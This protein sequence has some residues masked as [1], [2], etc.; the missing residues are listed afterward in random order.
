[1]SC[2]VTRNENNQIVR[3]ETPNGERSELFIKIAKGLFNGDLETSLN[4]FGT[5]YNRDVE[6]VFKGVT[7]NRFVYPTGEPKLFY[8]IEGD[9]VNESLEQLSLNFDGGVI[10]MGFMNPVDSSFMSVGSVNTNAS[11]T[12]QEIF[13]LLKDGIILPDRVH[14]NNELRYKGRGYRDASLMSAREAKDSIQDNTDNLVTLHLDGTFTFENPSQFNTIETVKGNQVSGTPE[15][16]REKIMSGEIKP[17]DE[18]LAILQTS[19]D[20]FS[21][22]L[23]TSPTKIASA[24]ITQIENFIKNMGFSVTT[25]QEYKKAYKNRHGNDPDV[26]ALVDLAEKL[27][28]IS[29]NSTLEEAEALFSEEVTHLAIEGYKDQGTLDS[30]LLEV[31][32][33]PEYAQYAEIY[34]KKYTEQYSDPIGLETAVRKEVLGKIIAN[35]LKTRVY[36]TETAPTILQS[37]FNRLRNFFKPSQKRAIEVIKRDVTEAISQSNVEK[38]S[39]PT[40]SN[41]VFYNL[42]PETRG[43]TEIIQKAYASADVL[44][45]L[46]NTEGKTLSGIANTKAI[47]NTTKSL[48]EVKVITAIQQSTEFAK[49]LSERVRSKLGSEDFSIS[50]IREFNFLKDKMVDILSEYQ[51]Y[52][53]NDDNFSNPSQLKRAR[54][55]KDIVDKVKSNVTTDTKRLQK[56]ADDVVNKIIEREAEERGFTEEKTQELRDRIFGI[57]KDINW[58]T[59]VAGLASEANEFTGMIV[60]EISTMLTKAQSE[61]AR[62]INPVV[63]KLMDGSAQKYQKDTAQKDS[64]GKRTGY[65]RNFL[66]QGEYDKAERDFIVNT[67]TSLKPELKREDV[68]KKLSEK[69]TVYDILDDL[70]LAQEFDRKKLMDFDVDNSTMMFKQEYYIKREESYDKANVSTASR[71]AIE[72]S[73]RQT[74]QVYN[75]KH[76]LD[77]NGNVDRSK[78]TEEDENLERY[79]LEQRSRI[80]S[81]ISESGEYYFGLNRAKWSEMTQAQKDSIPE[82]M[83]STSGFMGFLETYKG[84]VLFLDGVTVDSLPDDARLAFDNANMN[85]LRAF[86]ASQNVP[87]TFTAFRDKLV[88]LEN[89]GKYAEA[90]QWAMANGALRYTEEYYETNGNGF[91]EQVEQ[92]LT[93]I[94]DGIIRNAKQA[95]FDLLKEASKLRGEIL[96]NRRDPHN[97]SEI[98]ASDMSNSMK[99]KVLELDAQIKKLRGEL[100]SELKK[101]LPQEFSAEN[102]LTLMST[103]T[104]FQRDF[105]ASGLSLIE[106]ATKNMT[107]SDVDRLGDFRTYLRQI[108]RS[109]VA[110]TYNKRFDETIER[111]AEMGLVNLE[112]EISDPTMLD[113]FN[114]RAIKVLSEQFAKERVASY[115]KKYELNSKQSLM[116]GMRRGDIKISDMLDPL[117][118][119]N[120]E[121]VNPDLRYLDFTPDY[122]WADAVDTSMM[123]DEYNPERGKTP[124]F[125]KYKDS[126]FIAEVGVTEEQART[127]RNFDEIEATNTEMWDYFKSLYKMSEFTKQK[128]NDNTNVFQLPQITSSVFEKAF[129]SAG[130]KGRLKASV[131]DLFS[132]IIQDRVDEKEYGEY[133]DGRD[134]RSMGIRTPPRYF[135][136]KVDDN[137]SLTENYVS[138]YALM[139]ME[140]SKYNQKVKGVYRVEQILNKI[141]NKKFSIGTPVKG[142]NGRIREGVDSNTLKMAN[143]IV[144]HLLY[145]VKQTGKYEITFGGKVVDITKV[146]RTF[147]KV[148]SFKNLAFDP[149]IEVLSYIT[150]QQNLLSEKLTGVYTSK[151]AY[152][153]ASSL[154]QKLTAQSISSIGKVKIDTEAIKLLEGF[155]IV[156]PKERLEESNSTRVLRILEDSPFALAQIANSPVQMRILIDNLFDTRLVDVNGTKSFVSYQNFAPM[157]KSVNPELKNSDIEALWAKN[158][159]F[160][161]KYLDTSGEFLAPKSTFTDMFDLSKFDEIVGR[162]SRQTKSQMQRADSVIN[163]MDRNAI[164]RNAFGNLLMQHSGWLVINLTRMLKGDHYSFNMG[165]FEEGTMVTLKNVAFNLL[166]SARS[167]DS[168]KEIYNE[169][170][171][172][173]K[174]NLKRAGI[175]ATN[176]LIVILACMA[177]FASEDEDD[178]WA[179]EYARYLAVRTFNETKSNNPYGLYSIVKEKLTNPVVALGLSDSAMR[180][181]EY[182]LTGEFKQGWDNFKK[183]L[184]ILKAQRKLEDP[185]TALDNFLYFNNDSLWEIRAIQKLNK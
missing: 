94:Q 108:F 1:M 91:N 59:S 126:Y 7:D 40:T 147:Q 142:R 179:E 128:Y 16:L 84:S 119:S 66:N 107:P 181:M 92:A 39:A 141:K 149:S 72:E 11:T 180:T 45:K 24:Y 103:N 146:V 104:A 133:V 74:Y 22:T 138:A 117:Q 53:A 67:I 120:A 170:N 166:K 169:L 19:P 130:K 49:L 177:L 109:N 56:Q 111:Y 52:L 51:E 151:S 5:A 155:L 137:E 131:K 77:E 175:Q 23:K 73:K 21:K 136:D 76:L 116:D 31:G 33:T 54:A 20:L 153:K 70:S 30:A 41:G 144:D 64:E 100:T 90:Y 162:I 163:D 48:D 44:T 164:S 85:L 96:R 46:A 122:T 102:E 14:V 182:T 113:A 172:R 88:E 97:G 95:K 61:F 127:Y 123:N 6:E 65:A 55:V 57:N 89:Q 25:M 58:I 8:R 43:I 152:N 165:A 178:T 115:Y 35:G 112:E 171:P 9:V 63:N 106:F 27:V 121:Q 140:A 62:E 129:R 154:V 160:F 145:G 71:T 2:R 167:I 78:M 82:A 81:P 34:R 93:E 18:V 28:A 83:R 32:S 157:M 101:Y 60:K 134:L 118:K 184:P 114:E 26:Q 15:Q 13:S 38:F 12:S 99:T 10:E 86:E 87:S 69:E 183:T 36:S 79:A 50:D 156:S 150:G 75:Q 68:E 105:E 124:K 174:A 148:S 29:E 17:K 98:L 158:E 168:V 132:D 176:I 135:R 139:A 42:N 173:E 161:Y 47:L 110:Q 159:D 37:F 125:S 3:V 80:M 185:G 4:I 143:G